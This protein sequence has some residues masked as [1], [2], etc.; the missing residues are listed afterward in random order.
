MTDKTITIRGYDVSVMFVEHVSDELI[1]QFKAA[2]GVILIDRHLRKQQMRQTLL[3][4]LAHALL[5]YYGFCG[6]Q[7][8]EEGMCNFV[9][10]YADEL[11]S[12]ANTVLE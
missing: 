1:G 8:T 4:E 5:W 7:G 2:E 10:C 11:V 3:H 6:W 9:G 12:L